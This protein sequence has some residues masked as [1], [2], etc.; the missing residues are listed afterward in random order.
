MQKLL[1]HTDTA[2]GLYSSNFSIKRGKK[3]SLLDKNINKFDSTPI[4]A[5][6]YSNA[7]YGQGTGSILLDNVACTGTES[8][9]IDCSYDSHTADCSHS[10]DAA[11]YCSLCEFSPTCYVWSYLSKHNLLACHTLLSYA[12]Y[13]AHS[14]FMLYLACSAKSCWSIIKN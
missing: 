1:R 7:L 12:A 6:A 5:I 9:L 2:M 13:I 10:E 8:R 4:A 3:G 11:V 14:D